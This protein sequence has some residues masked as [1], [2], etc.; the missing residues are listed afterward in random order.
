[1]ML[2]L[3]S[4]AQKLRRTVRRWTL[5]PKIHGALRCAGYLLAG[6][7]LSA[8]SLYHQVLP[9][10]MAF[11]FA[12]NGWSAVMAALGGCCGYFLFWGQAGQQGAFWVVAALPIV[13][14]LTDRQIVR[15][16]PALMPSLA[17][18]VVAASG[19]VF[20]GLFLDGTSVAMYL[21]RVALA[22]GASRVFVLVVQG[23]N[24][25]LDWIACGMAV[26]ALA[27]IAPGMY[28][29]LGFF[30]AGYF[31]V[32]GAFPAAALAGLALDV[33]QV[34]P[35]PMTAV[36][37]LSYMVRFI[38]R[39]PKLLTAVTPGVVYVGMMV[40][41]NVWALQPVPGLLVGAVLG[42]AVPLQSRKINRRGET[43]VAQV[44]LEL[45]AGVMAQTQ[46]LLMEAEP[47]Q[48]DEDSL[49]LRAAERAC[50]GC[51]YRKS[52]KDARRLGQLPPLLLHKPLLSTQ[53]LPI[54]CRKSGR[55]LAELHRSQEQ[56][57]SIMADR[58]RQK[59]YRAAVTQQYRF[60][61]EFLQDLS[62][63]LSRRTGVVNPCYKPK[64]S[65]FGN[66]PEADNGDKCLYFAGTGNR[67][68]VLLCD[69]MGTGLGAVRE[70]QTAGKLLQR[71]LCA[72][73]PAE[74]ALRSLNSLCALRDRAGAVTVDLTEVLLDSGKAVLYKWGA[75]PSYLVTRQGAE[76][77]G[78]AGPPPGLSVTDYRET[79]DK[80]S[81]RRGELLVLVSDGIGQAQTMACCMAGSQVPPAELARQ[82]LS[83]AQVPGPDD[84]TVVV[85]RLEGIKD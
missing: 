69:G 80:V 72:G 42:L 28:L 1:M 16:S 83:G 21:I 30:A 13:I 7:T 66:R 5:D 27:Q 9:L 65:V 52:C 20:Q 38:P 18:F 50:N 15:N 44:R 4:Y 47:P 62:D 59:E 74:H 35:V 84:A 6:F 40:L 11:L 32:G 26:L 25:I 23:R 12:C 2:M 3:Q 36:L 60:V 63:S 64:V 43:G 8:A 48:V 71:L 19:V 54:V 67:Y 61:S 57:R 34:C 75:A 39:Y 56:L 37:A 77:I 45:A 33:A 17:A 41:C 82:I 10:S 29:N 73:Y 53:E 51:S 14:L 79:V 68:Y 78:V 55:F 24:P 46:Q 49:V 76:K 22:A 31:C 70:A 85:I 81:L 58:E